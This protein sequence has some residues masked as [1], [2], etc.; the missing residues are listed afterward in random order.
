MNAE[1]I[2]TVIEKMCIKVFGKTAV[3][4]WEIDEI[5]VLLAAKCAQYKVDPR[6]ALAQGIL[7]CHFG[8]NPQASRS[9]KT[10]NIWNVGNVDTGGNWYFST[11]EDG[12]SAYLRVLAREYCWRAEGDTVTPEMLIA[13]DFTRPRGGRYATAP[14]Y[15]KDIAAIVKKIDGLTGRI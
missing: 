6:L 4:P 10:K 3:I 13:H 1:Q 14:S 15:T 8:C 11:W 2:K 12:M 7:E 9:R 5:S